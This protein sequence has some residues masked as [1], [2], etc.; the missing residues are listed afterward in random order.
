MSDPTPQT[1][2]P[3]PEQLALD[4][5]LSR[6][7]VRSGRWDAVRWRLEAVALG[8]AGQ[9]PPT[10]AG[11]RVVHHGIRL[12]LYR[13]QIDDYHYNLTG[14]SPRLFVICATDPVDDQ[15]VPSLASLS[16]GDAVD[17][18]ET[19]G[20][21]LTCALEGPVR[22]WVEAWLALAPVPAP[23]QK[24]KRRHRSTPRG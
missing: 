9:R 6:E 7:T 1:A 21:V 22:Q 13:D 8:D 23:E 11:D 20:E 10:V 4:V 3:L 2:G 19:E 24:K 16:Q 5:T 12:R 14:S 17:A 15:L 18:L